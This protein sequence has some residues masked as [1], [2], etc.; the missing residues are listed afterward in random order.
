MSGCLRERDLRSGFA[1][2]RRVVAAV[3]GAW[4]GAACKARRA[5]ELARSKKDGRAGG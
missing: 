5:E 3:D 2:A 1:T 4:P